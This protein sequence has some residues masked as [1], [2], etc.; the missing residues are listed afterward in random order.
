MKSKTSYFS[1]TWFC[2]DLRAYGWFGIVYT[3]VLFCMMTLPSMLSYSDGNYNTNYMMNI[4]EFDNFFINVM[5]LTLPVLV[6]I[7][8]FR[9]LQVVRSYTIIHSYP[10]TRVQIFNSHILVGLILL[11]VPLLFNTVLMIIINTIVG[12]PTSNMFYLSWFLKASI[13]SSAIFIISSFIGVIVGGS[14]WQLVFSYIF[15][16]LPV[17][18]IIMVLYFLNIVVYGFSDSYYSQA[19]YLCPLIINNMS[20][21]SVVMNMSII[22]YI[23]YIIIFYPFALYLYKRRNL[24][25]V[26][27]IICFNIFKVIF[28]Y[29]VTFCFMLGAGV[30]FCYWYRHDESLLRFLIGGL[31]GAIIGYFVSEML[32]QKQINVFNK[33]KGL[34][35]YSLVIIIAIMGFKF[36]LLGYE[37]RVPKAEDVESID[38]N[39]G[40]SH[41]FFWNSYYSEYDTEE[42]INFIIELHTG[43]IKERPTEGD[44]VN[45]AYRLK[46]G[47]SIKRTYSI[48]KEEKY[49][50]YY[51]ALFESIEFKENHYALLTNDEENIYNANIY[52]DSRKENIVIKDQ[53]ELKEFISIAKQEII[54]ESYE[55][56]KESINLAKISFYGTSKK[57]RNI[58]LDVQL[59][60][61]YTNLISWLQEKEYYDDIVILPEDVSE[62]AITTSYRYEDKEDIFNRTGEYNYIY[63]KDKGK[64]QEILN[65]MVNISDRNDDIKDIIVYIKYKSIDDIETILISAERA[66]EFILKQ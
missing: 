1:K 8:L 31:V 66:P 18:L 55:N 33:Y 41:R 32:L 23:I 12:C 6:A 7:L 25:N 63:I 3:I 61:N 65:S 38:F 60:S 57:G 37:K 44:Q 17:G 28:K 46:N 19:N 30:V 27:S 64:I 48:D 62:M 50:Q 21:M 56:M 58:T 49:D 54:D 15:L 20:N 5:L 59:K 2:N 35:I 9:Y 53:Q 13:L 36:D 52:P 16:L 10:Y 45:I 22:A 47:K 40:Y 34:L 26:S 51:K 14:I 4:F 42:M 24:E 43:I 39:S 29:G 11:L